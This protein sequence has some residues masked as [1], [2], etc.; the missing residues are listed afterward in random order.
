MSFER[1]AGLVFHNS[2][3]VCLL[4]MNIVSSNLML[5]FPLLCCRNLQAAICAYYDYEQP[6]IKIPQM[7]F[8]Q[9]VTIGEGESV[10]P[11]T[12]FVKTWRIK[13]CGKDSVQYLR[14]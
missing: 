6:S 5:V 1:F 9:D 14:M 12:P 7:A 13:N 3:P 4:E 2:L 8:V 11:N 10:P